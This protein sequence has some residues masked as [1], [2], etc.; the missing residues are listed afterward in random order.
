LSGVQEWKKKGPPL[1]RNTQGVSHAGMITRGKGCII[2]QKENKLKLGL[3][4]PTIKLVEEQSKK[5][6]REKIF[7]NRLHLVW[8]KSEGKC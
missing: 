3:V 8:L 1:K 6:K 7:F 5:N 2:Q 4:Q